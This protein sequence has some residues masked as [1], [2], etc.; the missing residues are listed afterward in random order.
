MSTYALAICEICGNERR[1]PVNHENDP[2]YWHQVGG[3]RPKGW[4]YH[5]SH[6]GDSARSVLFC[7]KCEEEVADAVEEKVQEMIDRIR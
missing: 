1:D 7:D 6:S 2:T 5:M 4:Q 3:R